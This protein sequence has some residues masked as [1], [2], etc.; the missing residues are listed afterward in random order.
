MSGMPRRR[1]FADSVCVCDQLAY[2][3]MHNY[4]KKRAMV[5]QIMLC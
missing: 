4:D 3:D 1:P 2:G 5:Q